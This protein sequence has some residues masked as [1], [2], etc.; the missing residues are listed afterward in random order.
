MPNAT[1]SSCERYFGEETFRFLGDHIASCDVNS[2][3]S[4]VQC[5]VYNGGRGSLVA[6]IIILALVATGAAVG[7][8]LKTAEIWAMGFSPSS[9]WALPL[10]LVAL[11]F[12]LWSKSGLKSLHNGTEQVTGEAKF[13]I[14]EGE[15]SEWHY[16]DVAGKSFGIVADVPNRLKDGDRITVNYYRNNWVKS[17]Y[18]N[19]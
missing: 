3:T 4:Q 6:F 10:F 11:L 1:C 19:L 13:R 5:M 15:A 17:V 2:S 16:V 7:G 18:L 9:L 14:V 8:Y 12:F